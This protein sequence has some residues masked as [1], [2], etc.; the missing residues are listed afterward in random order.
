MKHRLIDQ[1]LTI[2]EQIIVLLSLAKDALFNQVCDTLNHSSETIA[3]DLGSFLADHLKSLSED[4]V[5][6]IIARE[7]N[8]QVTAIEQWK[9]H[10]N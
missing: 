6:A 1:Y 5:R 3:A 4:E 2:D 9:S 7:R 8:N 10:Q